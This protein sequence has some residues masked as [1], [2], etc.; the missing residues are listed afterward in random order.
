MTVVTVTS[1]V[2]A[3]PAGV[4]TI[5]DVSETTV[6]AIAGFPPKNTAVA[7]VKFEPVMVTVLPPESGPMSGLTDVMAGGNAY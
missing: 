5:M 7:S 1:T 6:K 4:T 3:I 2:P